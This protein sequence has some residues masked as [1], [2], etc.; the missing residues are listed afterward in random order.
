MEMGEIPVIIIKKFHRLFL[1]QQMMKS[2]RELKYKC[3]YGN[4]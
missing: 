2:G 4:M 3:K 1:I